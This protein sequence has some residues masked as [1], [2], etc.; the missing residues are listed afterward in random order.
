MTASPRSSGAL[1]FI[2]LG[3][4]GLAAAMVTWVANGNLDG[5]RHAIRS[6]SWQAHSRLNHRNWMMRSE[7]SAS[8]NTATQAGIHGC[9][10]GFEAGQ[11]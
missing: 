6:C 1:A 4:V 3:G 5:H 9:T 10:S 7:N 2:W 8:A 11:R